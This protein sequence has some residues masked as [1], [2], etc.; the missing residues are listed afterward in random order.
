M[1]TSS[2]F[3]EEI[4]KFLER[5]EIAPSTFGKIIM[6]DPGFITGLRDGRSPSLD[7]CEKILG[8]IRQPQACSIFGR[9]PIKKNGR[10]K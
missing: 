9:R 4:E 1:L 5:H 7:T 6:G 2:Q 8:I 3:L 10:Q